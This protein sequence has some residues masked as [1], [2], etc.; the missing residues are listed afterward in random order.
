MTASSTRSALTSASRLVGHWHGRS[1][2]PLSVR[3]AGDLPVCTSERAGV[4][5]L[6]W[7]SVLTCYLAA[8]D[9][10]LCN[11]CHYKAKWASTSPLG[12]A[13][14]NSDRCVKARPALRLPSS[15]IYA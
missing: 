2:H 14:L 15:E 5:R 12:S 6:V 9:L 1:S 8:P 13:A 7:A 4:P 11:R 3:H 10:S